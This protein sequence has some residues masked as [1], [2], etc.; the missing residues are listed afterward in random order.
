MVYNIQLMITK[1]R[2]FLYGKII[3]YTS[4]FLFLINSVYAQDETLTISGVIKSSSDSVGIAYAHVYVPENFV[5]TVANELGQFELKVPIVVSQIQVSSVGYK[6]LSINLNKE[7]LSQFQIYLDEAI[8]QLNEVVVSA[9]N[10]DS[11]L[12][13]FDR[14]FQSI[15]LNYPSKPHLMEGFFREL[16]LKDTLYTRLIEASVLVQEEGY[17]KQYFKHRTLEETKS[18]VRVTEL[19]KSDDFR[20]YDWF[21][22]ALT[23][24]FGQ[25]NELYMLL[26]NN[27]VRLFD[28][29][30]R[31]Y[32]M[33][34]NN[35]KVVDWE[36][37][38]KSEWEGKI[39]YIISATIPQVFR[40]EKITFYINQKDYAFVKIE[41]TG[42]PDATWKGDKSLL[43]NNKYFD[44][45]E[46]NYRKVTNKYYPTFIHT[47][48]SAYGATSTIQMDGKG[49]RQYVDVLYLLTNVYEDDYSKIKWRKADKQNS[50]LYEMKS[51][52]NEQFWQNYNT[53]KLNPLKRNV[54][55]LEKQ[56]SLS[57]QFKKNQ[58]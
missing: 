41:H 18:R 43:I 5:G 12:Y 44:Y 47:I 53:V 38:G 2:S 34:Y 58:K 26:R 13:F 17:N 16:S 32:L 8:Y 31:D 15:K 28:T 48:W 39:V 1:M 14:A 35:L 3:S 55:E 22:K 52:Y 24:F 25:R 19:R 20:E 54:A 40:K 46:V 57:E 29:K 6:T 11:A 4:F 36:Y 33:S 42:L 37:V 51:T 23:F 45:R 21:N 50:D 27:Y 9:N 56:N 7:S 30:V 10:F 49:V